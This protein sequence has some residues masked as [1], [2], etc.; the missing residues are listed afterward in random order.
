MA[1]VNAGL[2]KLLHRN[3]DSQSTSLNR[4]TLFSPRGASVLFCR[5]FPAV[6]LVRPLARPDRNN[7]PLAVLEAATRS[8]LPVLLPFLHTR[9]ARQEAILPQ[10]WPQVRIQLRERAGKSHSHR[11]SLSAHSAALP[12]GAD[13]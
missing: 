7:L 8:L 3:F 5:S 9:I 11:A 4:G 2:Q 1:E 13:F 10:A 12:S 6:D